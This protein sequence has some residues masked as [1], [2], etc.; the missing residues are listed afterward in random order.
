MTVK[1]AKEV[2]DWTM[3]KADQF[4]GKGWMIWLIM[5]ANFKRKREIKD[6]T[7]KYFR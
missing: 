3:W 1:Y 4:Q 5:K 6:T 2:N 7:K